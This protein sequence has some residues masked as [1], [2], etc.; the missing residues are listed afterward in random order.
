MFNFVTSLQSV[1]ALEV[2]VILSF[3]LTTQVIAQ[4]TSTNS[5]SK[6]NTK[7]S[8]IYRKSPIEQ[9]A[10]STVRIPLHVTLLKFLSLPNLAFRRLELK[11]LHIVSHFLSNEFG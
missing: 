9:T 1:F 4:C 3:N 8:A 5:S 10:Q 7:K 6:S 2:V 11:L